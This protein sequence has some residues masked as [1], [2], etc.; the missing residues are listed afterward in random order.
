[1]T[2]QP[3][4]AR[5]VLPDRPNLRHL[6][7]QAK[8]LL[9]AGSLESLAAAQLQ[10]ARTYGF[11]SWPKLKAHVAL[12]E[13]AGQLKEA[14][15]QNDLL[16]VQTTMLKK[17]S[18]HEAPIGYAQDGPLTWVAECRIPPVPPNQTR[19]EMA[20][21]M[22]ENGSDVHRGGDAPLMRA[23]L[24][25]ERIPMM[26][27][28]T[29]HGADVNA[30][31]HGSYPIIFAACEVLDPDSLRWLLDHGADPNCG[32]DE[33]WKTRNVPHPGTAL[34]Y[35]LGAYVR[36]PEV[37]CTCI[38]ILVNAGGKSKYQVPAVMAVIRNRLNDLEQLL[39]NDRSLVHRQFPAL[40]F[41]TTAARMLTLRG[42]TLLHVAA[43]FGNLDA[44]RLLLDRG[45]D[46]NGKAVVDND[47][48]GGQTAVFH[49]ATQGG[50][51]GLS[52]VR[53]LVDR[54]ADLTVRAKLPGHYEKP[55]EIVDCTPLEYALLFPGNQG[56]TSA[57]LREHGGTVSS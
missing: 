24:D 43:E 23:A 37:L 4:D 2:N 33:F 36:A 1:V 50:D 49:A 54:G 12:L 8:D 52:I 44:V 57:F 29:S 30:A 22:I 5:R 46:V 15:D 42:A 11:A 31:W 7:D 32:S 16:R 26:E 41:G 28:L 19:L 18:L 45:A 21:W 39:N 17:P 13:E 10:V 51:C 20:R 3:P 56:P 38:D 55:G 40:D 6:K 35:L 27:L 34:D 25:G 14:I 47:G 9:N 48:V 53:F